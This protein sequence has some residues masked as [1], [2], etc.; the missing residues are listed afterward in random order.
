MCALTSNL[1]R[2]AVPGN[3]LLKPGEGNLAAQSVINVS[4]I[5]TFDKSHLEERIGALSATRMRQVIQGL[6]L[7]IEPREPNGLG[8]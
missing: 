1:R 5:F 6:T 2:A 7:M 3:V 4:Q 8:E